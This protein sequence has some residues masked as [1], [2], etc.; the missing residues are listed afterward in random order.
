M[1]VV[2]P[3]AA[4]SAA[5]E[6]PGLARRYKV[7]LA[8]L[9][10][11]GVLLFAFPMVL[12]ALGLNVADIDVGALTTLGLQAV[13]YLIFFVIGGFLCASGWSLFRLYRSPR[14]PSGD[15]V[16]NRPPMT[17]MKPL[18]GDEH[19]LYENLR[20]YCVQD[21]PEYQVV[22]GVRSA[23][24]GA[25]PVVERLIEEFPDRDLQLVVDSRLHGPNYKV[26][27]LINIFDY[28]KHDIVVSADSDVRVGPGFLAALS[29][30][31]DDPSV[32]A[33]TCLYT[34]S[35][36]PDTPSRLG[37]AYHSCIYMPMVVVQAYFAGL[38]GCFGQAMAFRRNALEAIGGL[39]AV[40][41][42]IAD[43]YLLGK[44][45]KTAGFEL[46]RSRYLVDNVVHE[47][48][49]KSL[50]VHELRWART[51]FRIEPVGYF[52]SVVTCVIPMS[53]L[54]AGV[55]YLTGIPGAVAA[56]LFAAAVAGRSW[57]HY[58]EQP[59]LSPH[60]ATPLW[61]IPLRE[62][63]TMAVWLASIAGRRVKWRGER[64]VLGK[65]GTLIEE[66]KVQA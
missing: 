23:E 3:R 48:D 40:V 21:Y 1:A 37:A 16:A 33:V 20:T 5:A 28:A 56:G 17:I 57:L 30:D 43:D 50:F 46:R 35:S 49:L 55:L 44:L 45:I 61:L 25:I 9:I 4:G 65:D 10:L 34:A 26:S 15:I 59:V 11:G 64:F 47:K 14:G 18:C 8:L 66:A 38:D 31:F 24:D 19:K 51:I 39:A 52:F 41:F 54:G 32:G 22:F 53:A 42:R 63:V 62:C 2:E 7:G 58:Y 27:N 12:Q 60:V 29:E 13:I 36:E 6:K